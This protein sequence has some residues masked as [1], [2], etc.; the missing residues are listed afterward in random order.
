MPPFEGDSM[1]KVLLSM[2]L[3]M[4]AHV[5]MAFPSWIGVYGNYKRHDDRANPGQF[6]ILMNE[7]YSGLAAEVGIQVNDG[8]WVAY[9]MVY[10]G[11][12]QGNSYWTFTPSFQFPG[13]A[14][15]KYYFHGFHANPLR[16]NARDIWDSKNGLNY[17][18]TTSPAPEPMVSRLADGL[19][20]SDTFANG[21]TATYRNNLWLDFKVKN[22]G[23]PEAVG[24]LWTWNNWADWRTATAT[25][26]ADLANG[27]EQWGVDIQPVGDAYYHRS[28]G[29]HPLVP[30][31]RFQLCGR[32]RRPGHPEVRHLLPRQRHLVLGQQRRGRPHAGHRQLAERGRSGQRRPER[33]LGKP[34]LR[35][36]QPSPPP[37]IPTATAHLASPWPISSKWPTAPT[38]TAPRT[39]A[40]A[41]CA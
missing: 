11:N 7:D 33:C 27:F 16:G 4:T 18:F 1:K 13:G 23:A 40:A 37:T 6:S 20:I 32:H 31:G 26:E 12:V 38:P 9:P 21:I 25:K 15:V 28:L 36:P 35:Q 24:I 39:P 14:K 34:E 10:A 5:A 41:G 2:V 30:P 19:F 3:A 29:F 17:E 8:N 22:L